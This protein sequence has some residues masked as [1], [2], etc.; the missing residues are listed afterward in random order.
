MIQLEE[1]LFELLVVM[2][3]EVAMPKKK[4]QTKSGIYFDHIFRY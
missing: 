3:T 1:I 4:K 2:T